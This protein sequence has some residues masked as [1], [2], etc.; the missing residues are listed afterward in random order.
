MIGLLTS[1]AGLGRAARLLTDEL[2]R[3]DYQ[4]RCRDVTLCFR[5]ESDIPYAGSATF[6]S[7]NQIGNSGVAIVVLPPPQFLAALAFVGSGLIR[8]RYVIAYW[9]WELAKMPDSWKASLPYV[10]EVWVPSRFVALAVAS[11]TQK[12]VRI[13]PYPIRDV[14][15][16]TPMHRA[17]FGIRD[18]SVVVVFMYD[19]NSTIERKNPMAVIE[20]FKLATDRSDRCEL[21]IKIN[22]TARTAHEAEKLRAI[23]GDDSRIHII[24]GVL[25]QA[26]VFGLIQLSDIVI[27]LH[28]S[29]GFGLLL[30]EAM[31][32]GKPV[33]ATGW[34]GN[35]DF[36]NDENS[37]LVDF[38]LIP[39]GGSRHVYN[40]ADAMWADPN[41]AVAAARLRELIHDEARRR[42]LGRRGQQAIREWIQP[43]AWVNGLG[44]EYRRLATRT[45][46]SSQLR[47]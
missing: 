26:E 13:V 12:P 3:L 29:E 27:S 44:P 47:S 20:A 16:L 18:D 41:V 43:A 15:D 34:S 31:L 39:V 21:V 19:P 5:S 37:I 32:L 24:S 33:I 2:R 45:D 17:N 8:N 46:P 11:L 1:S 7:R 28:R 35:T 9:V 23:A 25:E 30:V 6:E 38:D 22:H 10:D 14:G 42:D 40:I 36:M 4:V